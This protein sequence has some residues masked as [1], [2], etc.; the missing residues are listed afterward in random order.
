MR[1]SVDRALVAD[2]LQDESLSFREIARRAN[3]SDWSVRSIARELADPE[4]SPQA[5]N[6]KYQP[7]TTTDWAIVAGFTIVIIGGICFFAWR[8][9][10]NG[11]TMT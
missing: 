2:L 10:P 4:S 11:G 9:P 3:C 1:G 7:L 6:A 5:R 8:M